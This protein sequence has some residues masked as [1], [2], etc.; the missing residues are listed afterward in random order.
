MPNLRQGLREFAKNSTDGCKFPVFSYCC[1]S[2][3]KIC[4][5]SLKCH[6]FAISCKYID[7]YYIWISANLLAGI[8]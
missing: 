8:V 6:Y 5:T 2:C 1:N 7:N 4:E 3:P